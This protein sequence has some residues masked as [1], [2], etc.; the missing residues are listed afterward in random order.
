MNR[1]SFMEYFNYT[2]GP[3]SS[4]QQFFIITAALLGFIAVAAGAFGAHFLK[5][6]LSTDSLA[7]FEVAVRY[8]MYH[9]LALFALAVMMG[10]VSSTWLVSAGWLFIAGVFIFSGSLY[11]LV[12][13]GIKILGAITPIGGVLLLLGWLAILFGALLS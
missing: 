2:R 11:G 12:F 10:F 8:Q 6:R 3:M 1:L 4:L 13:S 9:A 7:V 5:T